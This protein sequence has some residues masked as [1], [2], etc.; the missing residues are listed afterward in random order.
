MRGLAHVAQSIEPRLYMDNID[1]LRDWGR[2]KDY[3]RMQWIMLQQDTP[4]DYVIAT[5]KQ[6]TLREFIT[7]SAED[8]GLTFEFS[9]EGVA[10]IS[11]DKAPALKVG[12]VVMR[13]DPSYFR[14]A[15]VETLL[16]DPSKAKQQLGLEPQTRPLA[17]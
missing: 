10:S 1:S 17:V 15:E 11:G 7:W 5:G 2:A 6:Y 16:A 13:I 9:G 12:D 4:E 8:L 3:A 14:S